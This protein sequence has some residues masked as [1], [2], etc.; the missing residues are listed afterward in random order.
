MADT[1]SE[2]LVKKE[3]EALSGWPM[4][5]G[6]V[7]MLIFALHAS[8]H[9]VGAGD[10]WVAMACGRHFINH[11]VNTVEPF[12]ANSHKAGPTVEEVKA[13][14]EWAQWITDKVGIETVRHWHPTGWINQNWLTHV[15]FYWLAEL[16]PFADAQSL[17]FNTLV[18]W[19]FAVYILT[20]ICVY[21]TSRIL[22]VNPALAAVFSCFALFV[23][24]SFFDI[25][26]AGF[27]NLSVAVFLLILVLTTYRN[28]LYIWLIV[29]LSVLWCNLH[30]GYIY[31]FI[32]LAPFIMFNL[33]TCAAKKRFVSIRLKG[34]YH[35][36]AAGFVAFI[37]VIV[38]NPFHLTNLTHTFIISIDKHA[39]MWRN[40][41]EW[42]PAFEFSNPVG[43]SRPFL[44]MF[45]IG[46]VLIVAWNV[47]LLFTN[48]FINSIRQPKKKP[49]NT[50]EYSLPKIDLALIIIAALTIYMAIKSRRFI[51]I[52]AIVACPVIAMFIDQIIRSIS[53]FLNFKEF[54]RFTVPSMPRVFQ[55]SLT[56]CGAAA[57]LIFGL[58]W[59]YK[60]KVVYLDPWPDDTRLTSVFMRMTASHVKPFAACQFIRDNKLAGNMF[61]YWTEGGFIAWGQNPDP[62]TGRTPLQL[63]MDGRA[64][65]AYKPEAYIDWSNI[66]AGGPVFEAAQLRRLPLTEANYR[67]I[68]VWIDGQMKKH[69][70]WVILMP[71]NQF[72][73]SFVK[74]LET[75]QNWPIVFVNNKEKLYVDIN[76][77]QGKNLF[78]GIL[79]GSV[80]YPDQF[81]KNLILAHN[82]ILYGSSQQDRKEGL[83]FAIKAFEFEPSQAPVQ[84]IIFATRFPEL[85]GTLT[86]F[87]EDYVRTFEQKKGQWAMQDGYNN[88][89]IAALHAVNYLQKL[90]KLQEN[91]KLDEDYTEKRNRYEKERAQ[92][93]ETKRW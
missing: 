45:I 67:D 88:K 31:V 27:S 6:W 63:F 17:S 79:N 61:N 3:R 12:S 29:P 90:A 93:L 43:D 19:K 92:L 55:L 40:V 64:Q 82:T 5:L 52:A 76:T 59:G 35:T 26:P 47:V 56:A 60:F 62:V 66:M 42:H 80:V 18:Y 86:K 38:L 44:I 68:G 84:Q 72:D 32:M 15:I 57:V 7:A 2:P 4:I 70:V 74:G 91:V 23:G 51:P 69:N 28:I 53:A 37:A 50:S 30:G 65:A 81:S 41:N 14:P 1:I 78:E 58:W 9:M 89:I 87:C 46:C 24:R 75:R 83:D 33:L 54:G 22:G 8:T 13:W 20:I 49:V 25:R 16:S 71:I 34:I 39:E 77:P 48:G 10:T 36:L 21:Y 85:R 11:G 73:S